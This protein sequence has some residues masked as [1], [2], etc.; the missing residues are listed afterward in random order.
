MFILTGLL[1]FF[2]FQTSVANLCRSYI[3]NCFFT[4]KT[5]FVVDVVKVDGIQVRKL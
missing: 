5:I 1:F 4:T 2:K 3:S